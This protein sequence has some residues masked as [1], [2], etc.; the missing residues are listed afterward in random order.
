MG[1]RKTTDCQ[2]AEGKGD[3]ERSSGNVPSYS[4]RSQVETKKNEADD[5]L[6]GLRGRKGSE[7]R[8][9]TR[10]TRTS[11]SSAKPVARLQFKVKM[12]KALTE[13]QT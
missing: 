5:G 7:S 8:G 11:S 4:R 9:Q 13:T 3:C 12:K 10:S 1:G 6:N 2:R